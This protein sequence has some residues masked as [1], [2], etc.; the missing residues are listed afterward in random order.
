MVRAQRGN[1]TF[2][3]LA[4]RKTM[5][6]GYVQYPRGDDETLSR[7][8]KIRNELDALEIVITELYKQVQTL[9][10]ENQTFIK[11]LTETRIKQAYTD[12]VY[13]ARISSP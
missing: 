9:M 12:E 11:R 1:A 6:S 5:P 10:T 4:A 13:T 7:F 3:E 2:A 8:R